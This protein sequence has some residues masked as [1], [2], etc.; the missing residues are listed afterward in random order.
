ML[1]NCKILHP[2]EE[3]GVIRAL[4]LAAVYDRVFR[5]TAMRGCQVRV[6]TVHQRGAN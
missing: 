6:A 3:P 1:K 2:R 5:V 4:S